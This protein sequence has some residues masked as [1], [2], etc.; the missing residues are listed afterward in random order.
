M[1]VKLLLTF[2]IIF[3]VMACNQEDFGDDVKKVYDN[4]DELVSEFANTDILRRGDSA[5]LFHVY[6]AGKANRYLFKRNGGLKLQGD[7]IQFSLSDI[8]KFSS[9]DTL[10]QNKIIIGL[11]KG[12]LDKMNSLDIREVSSNRS[13]VGIDL[14]FF[15]KNGGVVFL[16]KDLS[17]VA[18]PVWQTYINESK[19][20]NEHWYYHK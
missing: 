1:T 3:F 12:L 11:F 5:F 8:E 19:K 17:S 16:V 2:S 14:Q 9:V 10:Q 18:N 4:R 13:S 20:I 6:N 7:T 15:L